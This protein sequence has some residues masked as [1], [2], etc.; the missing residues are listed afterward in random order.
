MS[1]A[2]SKHR[3]ELIRLL[4]ITGTMIAL[5]RNPS[6]IAGRYKRAELYRNYKEDYVKAI[7]DLTILIQND[8]SQAWKYLSYRGSCYKSLGQKEEAVKDLKQAHDKELAQSLEKE[9]GYAFTLDELSEYY[10]AE[11]DSANAF[12][13]LD[14]Y[15]SVSEHKPRPDY[16]GLAQKILPYV[17]FLSQN[18][19]GNTGA[20]Y[21]NRASQFYNRYYQELKKPTMPRFSALCMLFESEAIDTIRKLSDCLEKNGEND[22][23][24]EILN[25][26]ISMIKE[27][28]DY[29]LKT[30]ERRHRG[31]GWVRCNYHLLAL[32]YEYLGVAYWYTEKKQYEGAVIAFSNSIESCDKCLSKPLFLQK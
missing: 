26:R 3:K 2:T 15:I 11:K 27:E 30:A 13:Y 7:A 22:K 6:G 12:E 19:H 17:D 25:D 1:C 8:P 5:D 24:I 23:A 20:I 18:E 16:L 28:T 29:E 4:K 10:L 21:F 32:L 14:E 31:D 9:P